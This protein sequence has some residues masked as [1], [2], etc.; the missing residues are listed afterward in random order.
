MMR[1]KSILFILMAT[2]LL[3]L[4]ACGEN[5]EASSGDSAT[6]NDKNAE[7]NSGEEYILKL[8]HSY[9]Q[10]ALHHKY[11]EWLNDE[12]KERSDGRLSIDIYPDAQ[13]MGEDQEI[14]AMVQGQVDMI[15]SDSGVFGS[16]D[17]IWQFFDLP[18]IFDYD[19]NDINVFMDAKQE[20]IESENGGRKIQK[21]MEGK[22]IKVL[23]LSS[24]DLYGTIWTGSSDTMITDLNSMEGM[25]IRTTGGS[26][27]A[28]TMSA[29]GA[30]GVSISG[31]ELTTALQQ[32]TVDGMST[33]PLYVYDNKLPVETQ[34]VYPVTSYVMPVLISIESFE[35]LPEDLQAILVEAGR[36]LEE[37]ADEVVRELG[38]DV[39]EKLKEE[40][41]I[42]TYYP[43]E[44]EIEALKKATEVVY[45]EYVEEVPE[46]KELIEEALKLR[47]EGN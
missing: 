18:F 4:A 36:D 47:D 10:V 26:V 3:L 12:V 32:G 33:S 15:H 24:T 29:A 42:E 2:F 34:T 27:T 39:N 1:K 23:S 22:G 13:L 7:E 14:S 9:P 11:V 31:P 44:Q 38:A 40:Q 5:D 45:D 19:P 46:A 37:Y 6:E 20:F 28:N 41:S 8:A 35:A 43:T 25:K 17:P 16:F 21:M 30:S